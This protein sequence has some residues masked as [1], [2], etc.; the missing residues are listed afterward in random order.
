LCLWRRVCLQSECRIARSCPC[1]RRPPCW[2]FMVGYCNGYCS[3]YLDLIPYVSQ[4]H[5]VSPTGDCGHVCTT[6]QRG[7]IAP[8]PHTPSTT[9]YVASVV[10]K[11]FGRQ[12]IVVPD[13]PEGRVGV[14]VADMGA[15]LAQE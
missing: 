1:S 4:K 3:L 5:R 15:A 11:V 6:V 2:R 7:A 10:N 12:A 9:R 8:L 13:A 14:S